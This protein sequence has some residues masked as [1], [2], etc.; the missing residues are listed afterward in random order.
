[1]RDYP[2]DLRVLAQICDHGAFRLLPNIT[3]DLILHRV[4][5]VSLA[6]DQFSMLSG[7]ALI[8]SE[9]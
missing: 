4:E 7:K 8:I 3:G 6:L 2:L 1:V 9:C 5:G